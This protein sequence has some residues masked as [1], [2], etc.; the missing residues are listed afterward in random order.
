MLASLGR[1]LT[2]GQLAAGLGCQA[3]HLSRHLNV[4]EATGLVEVLRKG[5]FHWVGLRAGGVYDSLAAAVLSMPDNE[6]VLADDIARLLA[7]P[8]LGDQSD[9]YSVA[10]D[11][12][13]V[14]SAGGSGSL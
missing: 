7:M 5:R 9:P 12:G 1:P 10:G 14:A 8:S 13:N 4:L 11:A 3:S 6:G 2:A